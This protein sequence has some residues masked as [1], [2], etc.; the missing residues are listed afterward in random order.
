MTPG[1]RRMLIRTKVS[2]G[3]GRELSALGAEKLDPQV[4][5]HV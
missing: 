1:Q 4:T 3:V 5:D 2:P